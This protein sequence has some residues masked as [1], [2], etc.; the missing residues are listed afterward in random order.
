[1]EESKPE[2]C[3]PSREQLPAPTHL[4]ISSRCGRNAFV[5][6]GIG[7]IHNHRVLVCLRTCFLFFSQLKL[8]ASHFCACDFMHPIVYAALKVACQ[9]TRGIWGHLR[10]LHRCLDGAMATRQMYLNVVMVFCYK[11]LIEIVVSR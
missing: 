10:P 3:V 7:G 1:M 2:I 4:S 5:I 8:I 6:S 9:Y 11:W